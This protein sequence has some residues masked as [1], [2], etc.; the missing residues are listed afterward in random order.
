MDPNTAVTAENPYA[1]LPERILPEEM[2]TEQATRE[3]GDPTFGGRDTQR[4]WLLKYA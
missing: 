2:I 4:D 3:P 1:Q